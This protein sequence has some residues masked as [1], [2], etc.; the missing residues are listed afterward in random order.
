ML[1]MIRR[2]GTVRDVRCIARKP[3]PSGNHD[4]NM[5][6]AGQRPLDSNHPHP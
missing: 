3:L 4:P 5:I 1:V 6:G 2:P